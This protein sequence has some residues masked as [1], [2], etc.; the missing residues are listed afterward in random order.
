MPSL[1]AQAFCG[2]AVTWSLWHR[3]VTWSL[4]HT[5]VTWS[6]WHRSVT[7]SLW[8]TSVA[9]SLCTQV[10]GHRITRAV[11]LS[12]LVASISSVCK[13]RT[14]S[15][16]PCSLSS[17]EL[18]CKQRS[19]YVR[20]HS[21]RHARARCCPSTVSN[22]SS[23]EHCITHMLQRC[24]SPATRAHTHSA[25]LGHRVLF[26][27]GVT[28]RAHHHTAPTATCD[29]TTAPPWRRASRAAWGTW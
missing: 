3:S 11:T 6:L 15:L 9:W 29:E 27:R 5:S 12:A 21:A 26:H 8:H 18:L 16:P 23:S 17:R 10:G 1:T 14:L 22:S 20:C 4:W 2:R 19:I 13:A 28:L 24:P 25:A 7:W